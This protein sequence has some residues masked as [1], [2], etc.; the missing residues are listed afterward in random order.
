MNCA[1]AYVLTTLC[2]DT[3]GEVIGKNV[4]VTFSLHQAELHKAKGVENDFEAFQIESKWVEDAATPELVVAM[5]GFC[6][7]AREMQEAALR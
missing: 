3:R 6:D 5:R 2:L 7:I 1:N 4:G